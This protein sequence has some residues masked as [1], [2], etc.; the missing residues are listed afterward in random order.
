MDLTSRLLAP[1][2][3]ALLL[4]ACAEEP[5]P[6]PPAPPCAGAGVEQLVGDWVA[7]DGAKVDSTTRLRI[8]HADQALS[9]YW[10][11]GAARASLTA[12]ISGAAF[13]TTHQGA[14]FTG[15][16]HPERCVLVVKDGAE[17][18]V[19][20][21]PSL[22]GDLLPWAPCTEAATLQ[23]DGDRALVTATAEAPPEGC[24]AE[25]TLYLDDRRVEGALSVEGQSWSMVATVAKAPV[26]AELH[27]ASRCGEAP[28][29]TLGVAC[30]GHSA[31]GSVH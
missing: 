29:T 10:V 7:T 20:L 17:A 23:L 15:Q 11:R 9:L 21:S 27:R 1:C 18:P 22:K 4:A 26:H 14:A 31:P 5:P 30:L 19:E 28:P 12:P 25:A 2:G 13:A 6:P 8:V 16:I 3:L 24:V